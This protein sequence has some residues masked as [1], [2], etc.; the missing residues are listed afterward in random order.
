MYITNVTVSYFI[1]FH[2]TLCVIISDDGDVPPRQVTGTEIV[3]LCTWCVH[4]LVFVHKTHT[5]TVGR[6][7]FCAMYDKT[8]C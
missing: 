5:V 6:E 7:S 1:M 3:L 2:I 8:A 4:M